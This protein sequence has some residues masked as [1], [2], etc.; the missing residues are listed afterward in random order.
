[1][2]WAVSREIALDVKRRLIVFWTMCFMPSDGF[3]WLQ[4]TKVRRK[5]VLFYPETTAG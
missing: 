4:N 1:M 5:V 2:V 3:I